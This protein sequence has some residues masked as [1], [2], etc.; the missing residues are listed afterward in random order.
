MKNLNHLL[1]KLKQYYQ[2]FDLLFF[3]LILISVLFFITFICLLYI[4]IRD[5]DAERDASLRR[6]SMNRYNETC[7][8]K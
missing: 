5:Y 3:I 6:S 7:I 2:E 1:Q 4:N 8:P